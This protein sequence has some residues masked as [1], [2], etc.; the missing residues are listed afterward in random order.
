VFDKELLSGMALI[1]TVP[2]GSVDIA[3]SREEISLNE[4][5]I[6]YLAA[7]LVPII[8]EIKAKVTAEFDG[9]ATKWERYQKY[10]SMMGGGNHNRLGGVTGVVKLVRTLFKEYSAITWAP[11]RVLTQPNTPA[12]IQA[13]QPFIP[14]KYDNI[15]CCALDNWM[16]TRNKTK[17]PV[18][19]EQAINI[20][21][22]LSGYPTL[23]FLLYDTKVNNLNARVKHQH[24]ITGADRYLL[25]R[26]PTGEL[27]LVKEL[28][29]YPPDNLFLDLGE[30]DEAAL[31][32]YGVKEKVASDGTRLQ[33][34]QLLR[35]DSTAGGASSKS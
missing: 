18:S 34:A 6:K 5:T 28:F 15:G 13:H 21:A 4:Q 10:A 22:H 1:L 31:T 26:Y 24:S 2:T 8:E 14:T 32:P 17:I 11:F 16:I 30:I 9:C 3:A 19:Y 23:K 29:G 12:A 35:Y 27:P 7:K 25:I 33:P 20:G